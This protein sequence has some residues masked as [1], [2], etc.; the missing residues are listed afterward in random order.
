MCF[1]FYDCECKVLC[2]STD[3]WTY[4]RNDFRLLSCVGSMTSMKGRLLL[5]KKSEALLKADWKQD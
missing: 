4:K 3:P 1:I 2:L 5:D